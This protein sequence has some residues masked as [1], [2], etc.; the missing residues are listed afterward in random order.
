MKKSKIALTDAVVSGLKA[1][2]AKYCVWDQICPGFGVEVTP[3]KVKLMVAKTCTT[4]IENNLP[5]Q[6]R[7]WHTLGHFNVSGQEWVD[8]VT[9]ESKSR[10]WTV[11]DYRLKAMTLKAQVKAGEDPKAAIEAKKAAAVSKREAEAAAEL[12]RSLRTTVNQL[13]DRF[14][15]DHIGVEVTMQG[16]KKVFTKIGTEGNK[17]ST[18]KEHYRL[19]DTIIRPAI[20]TVAVEDI[21][22]DIIA[23]LLKGISEETPILANRVRSVLSA[24]FNDAEKW[25]YRSIGSNP[26]KV[27]SRSDENKRERNLS[28][29]EIQA[30]GR[31]L[32]AAENPPEGKDEIAPYALAAI[33]LALLTGMRKGEILATR[34]EW[35]DLEAQVITIPPPMH[36][37]GKKTRKPRLVLLCNTACALLQSMPKQLGNPFVIVGR[38]R[39]A[40]VNLQDP[41][42][43]VRAAAGL[44]YRAQWM[45]ANKEL[46]EKA[47]VAERKEIEKQIDEKQ[48]H[49]HDLRRTFSSVA[50]RLGYPELWI[51]A[52]LGHAANTITKGYARP[53][54]QDDPLT[55]AL[56]HIGSRISGLLDGTIDLE[57]EAEE[58]RKAKKAKKV[59]A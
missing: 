50:T 13:A 35:I 11:D 56:E 37:T 5:K 32:I 49:F 9:G 24:M 10:K 2:K 40:L 28:D 30:L 19:I 6:I 16:N 34:W 18:A 25:E 3:S 43:E 42:E 54:M 46:W 59:G 17:L 22:T 1:K 27:Q 26:V 41:W 14:I 8:P 52:L 51:S 4:V 23:R 31:A 45:E 44:D 58:A 47:S 48:A 55:N 57:K 36:K 29:K 39:K 21:G 20:G 33:R 38:Q 7:A 53:D 12:A 15:K